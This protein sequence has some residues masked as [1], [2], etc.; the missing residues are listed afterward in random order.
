MDTRNIRTRTIHRRRPINELPPDLHS[1]LSEKF[2]RECARVT[3][4]YQAAENIGCE[5]GFDRDGAP[6]VYY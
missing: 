4:P 5:V 6:V 3:D 2:W 1:A